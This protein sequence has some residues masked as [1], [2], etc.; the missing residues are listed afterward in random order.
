MSEKIKHSLIRIFYLL[1]GITFSY[2]F[3][4]TFI[5]RISMNYELN[6]IIYFLLGVLIFIIWY[7]IYKLIHK[8]YDK[9][10]EKQEL[11]LLFSTF[12]IF[13]L[14]F[15]II[16]ITL[17]MPPQWDYG[18]V[19]EQARSYV[20]TGD[21]TD[22]NNSSLYLQYHDNNIGLFAFWVAIF[23]FVNLFGV[24]DFLT[25]AT[26]VNAFMVGISILLLYLCLRKILD[27]KKAY[28]GLIISLFFV[29]LF[30]YIP[31]FYT[32]TLSMP[33]VMLILYLYLSLNKD[34]LLSK[35]NILFF[36]LIL[37]LAYLGG[38]IKMTTWV[39]F[40]AVLIHFIFTQKWKSITVVL[41]VTILF[42]PTSS[43]LW[44][45]LIV[46]NK[47]FAIVEN[48]YGALPWTHYLM[49]GVQRKGEQVNEI[50]C[51]GGYNYKDLE[52]TLFYK[53]SEES[54]EYNLEEYVRRVKEYGFIGYIDY[55]T[56]K[57]VN[58]WG[59]G[60]FFT[61]YVY[62]FDYKAPNAIKKEIR[63]INTNKLLYFEQGVMEAMVFIFGCYGLVMFFKKKETSS[64]TIIPLSIFGMLLVL[65]FWENRSRYLVNYIPIFI[66]LITLFYSEI[67]KDNKRILPNLK[68]LN[69][70][71]RKNQGK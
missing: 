21:R 61:D 47:S 5:Q 56:K 37:L 3:I 40:I 41:I 2:I 27:K 12:V 29:P 14:I 53:T 35:K 38:K 62:Q 46:E 32:D 20:L 51:I 43:I 25:V 31:I 69:L 36:L 24:T 13:V 11:I 1:F 50:R 57:A 44:Q 59:E 18:V 48:D 19:Y 65:L 68:K 33:F 4:Q 9:L 7:L 70:I 23:K 34:K 63:G 26:L 71:A 22:L 17:K 39:I 6:K 58:A 42:I 28:F 15:I 64:K 45:K 10:S 54:K 52:K 55:L 49:M 67:T 66:M 60:S 16:I 8:Y 30:T